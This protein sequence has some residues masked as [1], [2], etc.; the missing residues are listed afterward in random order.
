[1]YVATYKP[2]EIEPNHSYPDLSKKLG[3]D[4]VWCM[5]ADTSFDLWAN[6]LLTVCQ[7]PDYFYL[8]DC[9]NV[10]AIS[11]TK[12]E[13][14]LANNVDAN[15]PVPKL[16]SAAS[17]P[18]NERY[19]FEF[20]VS[21]EEL[22][23][24]L[25]YRSPLVEL[26]KRMIDKEGVYKDILLEQINSAPTKKLQLL[27]LHNLYIDTGNVVYQYNTYV[28]KKSDLPAPSM[29]LGFTQKFANLYAQYSFVDTKQKYLRDL[30]NLL[31][32]CYQGDPDAID[33]VMS[34]KSP[35]F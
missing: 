19:C 13:N 16:R 20:F 28:L 27:M 35:L 15:S 14:Y 6:S 4:P 32:A 2:K 29:G 30:H 26:G 21:K 9:K 31:K 5:S 8:S 3:F 33:T 23:D 22:L 11:K 24:N 25:I 17:I 34:S 1:M 18:P 7:Y 10:Y 12:W